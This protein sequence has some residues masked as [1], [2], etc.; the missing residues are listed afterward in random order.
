M[1]TNY[2]PEPLTRDDV[3]ALRKADEIIF[4]S[5]PGASHIEAVVEN[6]FGDQPRVYTKV[7]QRLFPEFESAYNQERKRYLAVGTS[8]ANYGESAPTTHAVA[9]AMFCSAQ[10]TDT[11]KTV[12]SLL[13]VGDTLTLS[14]TADGNSNDYTKAVELHADTLRLVVTRGQQRLIFLLDTSICLN[15]SARMVKPLGW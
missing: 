3:A 12:A 9:F 1:D 4:R 6:G 15:N 8:Y 7:E 14:W 5:R 2:T 11:W 10:F 13:K